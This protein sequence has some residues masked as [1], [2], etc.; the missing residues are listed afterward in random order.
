MGDFVARN[1]SG[2]HFDHKTLVLNGAAGLVQNIMDTMG[3]PYNPFIIVDASGIA[4]PGQKLNE[5]NALH[6]LLAGAGVNL[7]RILWWD[8][9][10]HG[11][12]PALPPGAAANNVPAPPSSE[13]N[14][15]PGLFE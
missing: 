5:I 11:V 6:G 15:S 8:I 12:Q 7:N 2:H 1:G 14:F 4:N 13:D 10:P 9:G 3:G